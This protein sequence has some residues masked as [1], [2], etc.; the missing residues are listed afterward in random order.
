MQQSANVAVSNAV[1][2]APLDAVL[3]D[4]VKNGN[5]PGAVLL[6]GHNGAIVYQKAV[7]NRTAGQN[8]E[9]MTTDTIF[10]LA[11]L[12]KVIATTTCVMRL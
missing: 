8:P 1:A 3:N 11:S 5:A 10:D 9:P 7:G 2:F 12:T 6:V 4:A